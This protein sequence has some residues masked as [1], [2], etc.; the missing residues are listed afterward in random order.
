MR[1][2]EAARKSSIMASAVLHYGP[3][4]KYWAGAGP[5]DG[6][7]AREDAGVG[8]AFGSEEG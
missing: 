7:P 4:P 6:A 5:P 2:I 8:E 1:R 3:V